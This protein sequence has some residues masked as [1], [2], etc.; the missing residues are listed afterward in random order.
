[1]ELAGEL[2]QCFCCFEPGCPA[3]EECNCCAPH[4]SPGCSES[5]CEV[6]VCAFD[7]FCCNTAWDSACANQAESLPQCG[8][9]LCV[10]PDCEGP[11]EPCDC[12]QAQA[13][14]G[15]SDAGCQAAVCLNDSFCCETLWDNLCAA[16][17]QE[18]CPCCP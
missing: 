11:P 14:V 6:A 17:A 4:A 1:M 5:G 12:C 2:S 18:V 7:S 10:G 8:C 15:C 9:C 16:Q 3:L 13:G